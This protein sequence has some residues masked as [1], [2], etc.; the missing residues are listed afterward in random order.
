M[1]HFII[2]SN[3]VT[4]LGT[5]NG[6]ASTQFEQAMHRGLRAVITRPSAPRLMASAGQ[7]SAHVGLWQ[8]MHTT[9]TVC[10]DVLRSTYSMWIIECPLCVSHSE[11]ACSQAWHPMHRCGS[12]KNSISAGTGGSYCCGSRRFAYS[13]STALRMRTAHT[14]YS[15]IFEIGSW[16]AIVARFTLL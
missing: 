11:Q 1:S 7:T 9:G 14:L 16:L 12:T 6:Q 10:T 3:S 13:G 2:R 8:C 4:I 5:P 15:G